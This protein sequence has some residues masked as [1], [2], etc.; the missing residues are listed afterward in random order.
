M[1]LHSFFRKSVALVA[2]AAWL[3]PLGGFAQEL[4]P[5]I[6]RLLAMPSRPTVEEVL[7]IYG[8]VG[9]NPMTAE[10]YGY[11]TDNPNY[12]P[13]EAFIR[14]EV[15]KFIAAFELVYPGAVYAGLG[16]DSARM[17]D[18][19]NAFYLR[20]GQPGRAIRLNA[21][22]NSLRRSNKE[23]YVRFL[24][25]NGVSLDP[26]QTSFAPVVIFDAT[27]FKSGG[28]SQSTMLLQAAVEEWARN[29][30]TGAGFVQ[31][32]NVIATQMY[33]GNPIRAGINVSAVLERQV[34]QL[35]ASQLM[36]HQSETFS[37]AAAAQ[38][39]YGNFFWHDT[40]THLDLNPVN[41]VYE[42]VLP[43]DTSAV[44]WRSSRIQ[45]LGHIFDAI[46]MT[47]SEEFLQDVRQAAADL[48]F[49][50]SEKRSTRLPNVRR[51]SAEELAARGEA[52]FKRYVRNALRNLKALEP[53][54]KDGYLG[55]VAT[56]YAG[57]ITQSVNVPYYAGGP[58]SA[59]R[60]TALETFARLEGEWRSKRIGNRDLRRLG[61]IAMT[62]IGELDETS[63]AAVQRILS[64]S[65][66]L[67]K[68]LQERWLTL[69]DPDSERRLSRASGLKVASVTAAYQAWIK[70][71]LLEVDADCRDILLNG[72]PRPA[73]PEP[74]TTVVQAESQPAQ[75]SSP[76]P[77][78]REMMDRLRRQ[79]AS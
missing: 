47:R 44:D 79:K 66:E 13:A 52:A 78:Y 4:D 68:A 3:S 49:R 54:D 73:K 71:G 8:E 21:S 74:E 50:F 27:N 38:V 61:A 60:R 53:A 62:Y 72:A 65:P 70:R 39:N 57:L 5:R 75:S 36:S 45:V 63:A 9:K 17:V 32:I 11:V 29:G 55:N 56:A 14:A 48:G 10:A 76:W 6:E 58:D 46:V 7:E 64:N 40:F 41:G 31:R 59:R 26:K 67:R 35:E 12:P 43:S 69:T 22:G 25:S 24:M 18:L 19:L 16:R 20:L 51:P 1:T 42:G 37:Y 30:G 23:G 34:E 28:R 77:D 33:D 15:P 2:L